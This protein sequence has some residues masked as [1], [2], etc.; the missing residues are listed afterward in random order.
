M[1]FRCIVT[2]LEYSAGREMERIERAI[3][4]REIE[5]WND[6]ENDD[7]DGEAKENDGGGGGGGDDDHGENGDYS[8]IASERRLKSSLDAVRE[9]MRREWSGS[10][11]SRIVGARSSVETDGADGAGVTITVTT[12]QRTKRRGNITRPVPVPF[13]LPVLMAPKNV[14]PPPGGLGGLFTRG[15]R[16]GDGV[17]VSGRRSVSGGNGNGRAYFSSLKD[18]LH[19][20]TIAP[21]PI[22]GYD[23]HALMRVGNGEGVVEETFVR[24]FHADGNEIAMV[25]EEADKREAMVIAG[26]QDDVSVLTRDSFADDSVLTR[27]SDPV[28]DGG[29][30]AEI[31]IGEGDVNDEGVLRDARAGTSAATMA[32]ATPGGGG[33]DDDVSVL[34]TTSRTIACQTDFGYDTGTQTQF[35]ELG[36]VILEDHLKTIVVRIPGQGDEEGKEEDRDGGQLGP[37]HRRRVGAN[38]VPRLAAWRGIGAAP[39]A[40]HPSRDIAARRGGTAPWTAGPATAGHCRAST[41]PAGWR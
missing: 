5:S 17:S 4:L 22:R 8:V 27:D 3:S 32:G 26:E 35:D 14:P 25:E 37:V 10:L 31:A 36:N 9:A 33:G 28:A 15:S 41:P 30:S 19:G 29:Q 13:P 38:V 21:D 40:G 11:V 16:A 18:S 34:S 39:L 7:E 2:S 1:A 20:V 23:W 12:S 24:R 6:D